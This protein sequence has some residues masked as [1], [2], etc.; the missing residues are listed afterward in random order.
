MRIKKIVFL[1]ISVCSS[2]AFVN[3]NVEIQRTKKTL[4][5]FHYI[6]PNEIGTDLQHRR[7]LTNAY[8]LNTLILHL[9]TVSFIVSGFLAAFLILLVL[10]PTKNIVCTSL[11]SY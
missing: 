5:F 3:L 10:E 8:N 9:Q 4:C 11:H 6:L 1:K 7:I 2:D